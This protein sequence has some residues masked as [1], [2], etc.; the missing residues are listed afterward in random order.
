M[1]IEQEITKNNRFLFEILSQSG[2]G[3]IQ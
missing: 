3:I 2:I 1:K